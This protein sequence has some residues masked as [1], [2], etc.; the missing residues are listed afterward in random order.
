MSQNWSFKN[1][2]LD[3]IEKSGGMVNTHAHIDRSNTLGQH[4][5]DLYLEGE[6]WH[7]NDNPKGKPSPLDY[8]N[9]KWLINDSLKRNSSVQD[10]YDRMAVT[11]NQ[12]IA[13]GVKVLCSYIDIDPVVGDKVMEA[14]IRIREDFKDKITILYSQQTHYGILNKEARYW[15]DKGAEFVDMIGGLPEAEKEPEKESRHMDIL[16]ETAKRYNKILQ[17]HIDQLNLPSQKQTRLLA[18]K[19][20]QFGM[21]NRVVGVHGLSLAAQEKSYRNETYKIMRD[22]GL[23]MIVCPTAWLDTKRSEVLMPFHNSCPPV[24]EFIENGITVALGTDGI[25]DVYVPFCDGDMWFELRTLA[26]VC[27]FSNI[28]E[29]VKIAS[30]NGRKVLGLPEFK[31]EEVFIEERALEKV[32]A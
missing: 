17:V 28:E 22:A 21:E 5:F 2:I 15:F 29:L 11:V 18:E 24:D 20:I 31:K 25:T 3:E 6:K 23:M 19:T 30:T 7:T 27:R 9:Y 14:A 8:M 4:N 13:Q 1:Y 16:L 26:H 12:Q 10:Y 32:A